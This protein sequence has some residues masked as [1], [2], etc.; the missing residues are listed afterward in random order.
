LQDAGWWSPRTLT[1]DVDITWRVQIAGWH[2]SYAPNVIVWILMPETLRGLWHQRLRWA[3]GGIHM[4]IDNARPIFSGKASSLLP[5]Y[6]NAMIAILWA[7]CMIVVT[8]IGLLHAAHM[9]ILAQVPTLSL[10][11]SSYGP[12]LC[13]TYL[14]QAGLSI[15]LEKRFEPQRLSSMFWVIWYP[16]AFWMLSAATAVVSLPRA[17]LRPRSGRTTWVSPDRG[18]R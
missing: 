12:A 18:L 7:Y 9:H 4:L 17:L 14:L 15:W 5:I 13:I 2:I 10:I 11:P 6:F 3:E 1:D 8:A 16:M